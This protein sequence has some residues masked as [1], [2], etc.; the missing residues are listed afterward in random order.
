MNITC[1][2]CETRYAVPSS[3]PA[4][5]RKVKC[6]KCGE[7]WHAVPDAPA[8][9]P[10]A[11]T[12]EP[13]DEAV[14]AVEGEMLDALP[15][16]EPDELHWEG[17]EAPAVTSDPEWKQALAEAEKAERRGAEIVDED[18]GDIPAAAAARRVHVRRP[19]RQS[20]AR[21][22]QA[23]VVGAT[24]AAM[25]AIVINKEQ[26]VA[27][28]PST[29]RL[30]AAAG[31]EVN[32]RGL[33]FEK[34]AYAREQERGVPVLAVSGEIVNVSGVP[35][36]V[37][38]VRVAIAGSGAAEIYAWTVEPERGELEPGGRIPFKARLAA[39]PSQA[40]AVKLRFVDAKS[41]MVGSVQ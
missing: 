40:R 18:M 1:P 3:F 23:F 22:L 24:I 41:T 37:P 10:V 35:V 32:I 6:A 39:P 4:D 15:R 14:E 31:L 28:F 33:A 7:A 21:L 8:D 17:E 5:G 20:P 9:E 27:A 29:A 26:V 30:F 38:P 25:S 11:M 34:L 19:S 13:G 2:A 12:S 36:A 16:S